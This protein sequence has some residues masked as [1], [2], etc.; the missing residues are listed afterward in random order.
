V[1]EGLLLQGFPA[2]WPLQGTTAERY[3]QIGNAVPPPLSEAMGRAVLGAH[4]VW[5]S[6]RGRGLDVEA[7]ADALRRNAATLPSTLEFRP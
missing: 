5:T 7:L 4:R 6:L 2:D 1:R 3:A